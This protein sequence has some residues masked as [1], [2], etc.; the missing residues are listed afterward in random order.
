[1]SR[2]AIVDDRDARITQLR[3]NLDASGHLPESEPWMC[4]LI[5]LWFGFSEPRDW[6]IRCSLH[7]VQGNDVFLTSR[8]ASGKSII[9]LAPVIARQI[10]QRPY[11]A[12]AVY[13]TCSLMANQVRDNGSLLPST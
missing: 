7:L 2:L 3:K 6:Q 8:T 9:M 13:P 4:E 12:I 1:M 11:L 10:L 5:R